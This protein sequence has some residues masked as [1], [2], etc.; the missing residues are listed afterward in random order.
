MQCLDIKNQIYLYTFPS[1]LLECNCSILF[2]KLSKEAIIIDPGQDFSKVLEF[3]HRNDLAVRWIL[4][5]HAHFDHIGESG[6]IRDKLNAKLCLHQGDEW[7]F[8]S[9]SEQGMFFGIKLQDQGRIDY[10]LNEGEFFG[11]DKLSSS[12]NNVKSI[13]DFIKVIHCP[14]HTQ[15]SVCFYTES[16]TIPILFSGDTLF[17]NSIGRTDL[18][19]G[20][21]EDLYKSIKHKLWLLPDET[22]I[23]P[24]HGEQ[25]FLGHEKKNN[26]FLKRF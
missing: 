3:I 14:G 1:G 22:I 4:H 18:P 24:G 7:L 9:L 26:P 20:N 2:S 23:I 8:N 11:F 25:T 10:F 21:F 13:H 5:T 16:I 19:G 15:G 17:L 12:L 6:T